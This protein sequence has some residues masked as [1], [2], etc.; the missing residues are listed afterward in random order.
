[1]TVFNYFLKIY[2]LVL[3]LQETYRRAPKIGEV[4][5]EFLANSFSSFNPFKKTIEAPKHSYKRSRWIH[6]F[7]DMRGIN[8]C[9]L[10][11]LMTS[12]VSNKLEISY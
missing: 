1:M 5:V 6:V 10:P 2:S 3:W 8:I 9:F 12:A 11:Q 7:S 4:N